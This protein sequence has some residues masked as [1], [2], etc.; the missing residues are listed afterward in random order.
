ME[1]VKKYIDNLRK[2]FGCR[3]YAK[4]AEF[5]GI[6]KG[7]IMRLNRGGGGHKLH[8]AYTLLSLSFDEMS[9]NGQRRVLEKYHSLL[10]KNANITQ[11]KKETDEL[12]R[13][14]KQID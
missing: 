14:E 2:K 8:V 9:K 7:T 10:Y 1:A 3:S 13:Q 5:L 12:P 6:T 11:S 4:L